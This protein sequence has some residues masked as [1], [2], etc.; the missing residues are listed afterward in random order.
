MVTALAVSALLLA[1]LISLIPLGLRAGDQPGEVEL[2]AVS[3][4][5]TPRGVSVTVNNPGRSPNW[6]P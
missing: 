6:W 5:T 2:L 3:P 1:A 4:V